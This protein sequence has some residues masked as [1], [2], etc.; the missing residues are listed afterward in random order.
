MMF[1]RYRRCYQNNGNSLSLHP[2]IGLLHGI[3]IT[4]AL[5]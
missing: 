3:H 2:D 5:W 4:D 1:Q